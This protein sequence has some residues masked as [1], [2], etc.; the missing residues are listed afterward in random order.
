MTNPDYRHII[1]IVDRSG[2]MHACKAA[3]EKGINAL[4]TG[5]VDGAAAGGGDGG[6]AGDGGSGWATASLYQFD[7][8]HDVVFAHVPLAEA[9][10]YRLVPRGGTALLDAIGFAFAQEG[11]WLA[12]LAEHDRPGAVIAVIATDGMEN[13]SREYK[14]P[15]I[16]EIITHQQDVYGWQT[17]L[18]GANMD[19][20]Q[21]ATSYGIPAQ[22][23]LTFRASPAGT[24]SSLAAV[25][26]A[27][28]RG[29]SGQGYGFT[30]A[31]RAAALADG[32]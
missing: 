22:H 21:V 1:M 17:L 31:E 4:F 24:A 32:D 15:Q 26:N 20:V 2:S 11:E 12:S 28:T 29:R 23:A 18:I 30:P 7:T 9:P 5:Q 27:M 16:Q 10:A 14:R 6:S 19:A 8:E 3:T 13:A 25:S